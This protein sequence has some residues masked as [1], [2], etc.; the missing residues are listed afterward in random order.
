MGS[1]KMT[2]KNAKIEAAFAKLRTNPEALTSV[3]AALSDLFKKLNLD[4]N[5]QERLTFLKRVFASTEEADVVAQG[6]PADLNCTVK[7][8]SY[9]CTGCKY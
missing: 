1:N 8:I 3:V 2:V 7:V 6:I 9:Q 5:E 4:L